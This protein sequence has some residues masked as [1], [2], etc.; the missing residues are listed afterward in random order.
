MSGR[1]DG[2]EFN[3]I[4]YLSNSSGGLGSCPDGLAR[5]SYYGASAFP[6]LVWQGTNVLVGA[7]TDVIDGGPYDAIV[8]SMLPDAT[9]WVV[10]ITDF[11]LGVSP[12]VTTRI[13]LEDDVADITGHVVHVG[14]IENDCLYAGDDEQDVLRD[15]VDDIAITIDGNGQEQTHTANF[16]LD[17]SWNTANM[18]IIAF[19]QRDSDK[20][21]L[22]SCNSV[23]TGP[24]AFRYYSLGERVVVDSGSHQFDEFALFNMGDS[25]DTYDLALDTSGMPGDWNAYFTDGVNNYTSLPVNLAAGARASFNVVVET[26]SSGGGAVA[27]TIHSQGDGTDRQVKYSVITA[28]TEILLVDDDGAESFESDYYGPA[29]DTTGRSYAIWDRGSAALS[30]GILSNFSVVVWDVGFAFP[31]LDDADRAALGAYLD[32]GGAL[33]ISGQDV[34]WDSNDQ[35]GAALVW[36]HDYLHANYVADNTNDHT[37]DGVPGD[38]ISDGMDLVIQGG[39]GANNQDYPDAI[40]PRDA[41]AHTILTYSTTYNAGIAVDTPVYRVVYLGFGF[42]AIDNAADR[43]QLMQKSVLWLQRDLTDTP[44]GP[45]PVALRLDQNQPNPFNPKT[46]IR[47]A[48]P[49]AGDANLSV[50]DA[51]GRHLRVLIDGPQ[52]AGQNEVVWDG[53]DDAGN[54]LPSGVYFYSLRSAEAQQTRKMLLLK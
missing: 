5:I 37:L 19:L 14:L 28:D 21:I 39:D 36:Y 4:R 7:G 3:S 22:Q 43:A 35:G 50:Y 27:L 47:Y 23:P 51:S 16:T 24:Y 49:S 6:T 31:T 41:A 10:E 17:P 30:A 33:F 13:A 26:G 44:D 2:T 45:V 46:V 29:L 42:E 40:A 11:D 1:Y 52:A 12:Y 9:P 20:V 18:R 38:F 53:K 15:I 48:L 32:G 25:S 8:Q 34:G 54:T